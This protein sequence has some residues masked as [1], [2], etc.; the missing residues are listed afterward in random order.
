MIEAKTSDYRNKE[1]IQYFKDVVKLYKVFDLEELKL[2]DLVT[3]LETCIAKLDEAYTVAKANENTELLE[4]MDLRR[5]MAIVGIRLLALAYGNYFEESYRSA[6]NTIRSYIDKY[7]SQISKLT[8]IAE[9]TAINGIILDFEKEPKA[10]E[11]IAFL[12]IGQWV[13]ELKLANMDFNDVYMKRNTSIASQPDQNVRDARL[14]SYP[15]FEKLAS[16]TAAFYITTEKKD[17]KTI[18]DEL[19]VLTTKYNDTIPKPKPK[20]KNPEEGK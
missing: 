12:K 19:D 14:L 11:A 20:P 2:A 5:D 4:K 18:T 10:K 15:V 16:K 6:G 1:C 9:T 8:Y 17:Y 7:G 13:D 3:E